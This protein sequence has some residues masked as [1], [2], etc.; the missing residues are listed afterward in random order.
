MDEGPEGKVML[1]RILKINCTD[2]D[3]FK[4]PKTGEN[5]GFIT[6][7]IDTSIS[8]NTAEIIFYRDQA[9]SQEEIAGSIRPCC[10]CSQLEGYSRIMVHDRPVVIIILTMINQ[11]LHNSG[12]RKLSGIC[13]LAKWSTGTILSC[14]W[15]QWK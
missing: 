10:I 11:H 8:T 12:T 9:N 13:F 2:V 7:S 6:H 3:G 15:L 1:E 5:L 14:Y 4:Q